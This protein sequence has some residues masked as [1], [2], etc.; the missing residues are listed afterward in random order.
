MDFVLQSLDKGLVEYFLEKLKKAA[1]FCRLN[2]N[3]LPNGTGLA[4]S[5]T[6]QTDRHYTACAI[7][8][9][10]DFE[11]G[12]EV[13]TR[14]ATE[15]WFKWLMQ[16]SAFFYLGA[17]DLMKS[18]LTGAAENI[19]G[20][21]NKENPLGRGF[22]F[23]IAEQNMASSPPLTNVLPGGFQAVSAFA[24]YGVFTMMA[25]SVRMALINNDKTLPTRAFIMLAAHDGAETGED[26][27]ISPW[28][29]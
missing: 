5:A 16:Q 11:E 23:G 29:F 18:I 9:G 1:N 24:S 13:A 15:A 12:T 19:Y 3:K 21:I 2:H 27:P 20:I 7:T 6:N 10:I 17:G 28:T 14:K 26:G 8:T 4:K 22:R 25:N